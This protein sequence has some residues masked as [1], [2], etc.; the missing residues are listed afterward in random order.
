MPV[1][2]LVTSL[3]GLLKCTG[4]T[5]FVLHFSSLKVHYF[6]LGYVRLFSCFFFFFFSLFSEDL[7]SELEPFPWQLNGLLG[8][9]RILSQ[10]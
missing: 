5:L 9:E 7:T 6:M 2:F 10:L 4:F 3:Y 8:V 1:F